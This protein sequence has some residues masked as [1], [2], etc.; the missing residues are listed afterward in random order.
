MDHRSIDRDH[1][2]EIC[3]H[4]G[5]VG[6]IVELMAEIEDARLVLQGL[7]CKACAS[8]SRTSF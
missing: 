4:R 2:I 8:S 5:G 3:D 6:K 7:F 1:Q